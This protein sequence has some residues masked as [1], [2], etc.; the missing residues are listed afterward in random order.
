M[1][2]A[3]LSLE[4]NL[5]G[6][7]IFL[8][9]FNLHLE[10]KKEINQSTSLEILDRSNQPV[11]TLRFENGKVVMKSKTAIGDLSAQYPLSAF[12]GFK[13]IECGGAFAEWKHQISFKVD[14]SQCFLGNMQMDIIMD[15]D[16]G[17]KCVFHTNLNYKDP[18]GRRVN[19]NIMEGGNVF[20]YVAAKKGFKEEL[21]IDPWND[22][23]SFMYHGIQHGSYDKVFDSYP[24]EIMS[25]VWHNSM[26]DKEHIRGVHS[27]VVGYQTKNFRQEIKKSVGKHE[28]K[29]ATIQKGLLMQEMDPNFAKVME[30]IIYSFK[31]GDFSFL[32]NLMDVSYS[33]ISEEERQALFGTPIGKIQYYN[34]ADNITDAY[35]GPKEQSQF[36]PQAVYQKA[37][38]E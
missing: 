32:E 31:S 38:Q 15:T 10:N 9:L 29:A 7:R 8:N 28:S 4:Q 35:F 26:S 5:A 37:I 36:T 11:G 2:K 27:E 34:G 20:H 3:N 17:N 23:D 1:G 13:D 25:F 30:A 12:F 24:Q 14:G 6:A 22:M 16:F 21:R 18:F 33:R 19:I